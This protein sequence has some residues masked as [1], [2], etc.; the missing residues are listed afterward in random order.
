MSHWDTRL[1]MVCLL[2]KIVIYMQITVGE[3][4]KLIQESLEDSV[5]DEGIK[6]WKDKAKK[7]V[8]RWL[9]IATISLSTV[10]C[11]KDPH[12]FKC[13][14]FSEEEIKIMQAAAD[15]WC[16]A[17]DQIH[18]AVI[19]HEGD[20]DIKLV[21]KIPVVKN[22]QGRGGENDSDAIGGHRFKGSHWHQS[23]ITVKDLRNDPD[24]KR[25][26]YMIIQHELGH[27]F[28]TNMSGHIKDVGVMA[29]TL[30]KW[31]GYV[32]DKDLQYVRGE[33]PDDEW[34]P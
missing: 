29:P 26:L 18:C 17:S 12:N 5:L 20:S 27:H 16:E 33:T 25:Q 32:T 13:N 10:A 24:W 28:A 2:D 9:P 23:D 8:T 15:D 34:T 14:G 22:A 11:A 30:D 21:A 19:G 3:L 6:D 7:F 31:P 4:R 1:G